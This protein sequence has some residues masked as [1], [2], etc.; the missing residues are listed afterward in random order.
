MRFARASSTVDLENRT[1]PAVDAVVIGGGLSGLVCARAIAA[2]GA[3]VLVL[4]ARDR[5]GGRVRSV[6]L[7][8]ATVDV[9]AQWLAPGQPR[10][11]QL[12]AELGLATAAQ[13]RAGRALVVRGPDRDLLSRIPLVAALE[14]TVRSRALDRLDAATAPDQ[15][16]ATWLDENVRT[17]RAR[18]L[19]AAITRLKLGCEPREVS[20]RSLAAHLSGSDGLL[21]GVDPDRG[22]VEQHLVGGAGRLIAALSDSLG[23]AIRL[24][25]P[26]SALA[27]DGDRVTVRA[28]GLEVR[29]R[30][31]VLALA[32][33]LAARIAGPTAEPY[34]GP[35]AA[36]VAGS[37]IK[38]VLAYER[39]FWRDAGLS[40]ESVAV[41]GP[42]SATADVSVNGQP[43]LAALCAGAAARDLARLAPA[44]RIDAITGALARMYG[45][46]AAT[47]IAWV[48]G[49]W[50]LDPLSPGCVVSA[51][52]GRFQPLDRLRLPARVHAA[53]T[54]TAGRWAGYM[55]GAVI[56]GERAAAAV[57]AELAAGIGSTR[58]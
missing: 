8:G 9:G 42:V 55:E 50:P 28:P 12:A 36:A 13:V 2:T 49:N 37:V 1:R 32:P 31:A 39:P 26:V 30:Q 56:A 4:E 22:A 41:T 15:S 46:P 7:A 21:G 11:A 44:D 35:A 19:L 51:A 27:V 45:A 58:R 43:A 3:R 33:S 18:D 48:E 34:R 24:S 40:G 38:I 29:A 52:P 14:L 6:T 53:G 16:A 47:P 23:D 10:I 54:E 5:L 25:S 17:A 20:A 57:V